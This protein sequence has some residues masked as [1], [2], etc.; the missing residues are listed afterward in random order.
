M[1]W[2]KFERGVVEAFR[3][4]GFTVTGFGANRTDGGADLGL[5]KDGERFLVQCRHWQK[6]EIGVTAVW[7]LTADIANQGAQGGFIVTGGWFSPAARECAQRNSIQL[8]D[9]ATLNQLLGRVGADLEV[10]T[11]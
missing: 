10:A 1:I 7:S 3:R 11:S 9:G 5:L 2:R 8:F 4:R 6:A